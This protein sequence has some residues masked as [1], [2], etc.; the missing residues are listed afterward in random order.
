MKRFLH[1]LL[2]TCLMISLT[3]CTV[4]KAQSSQGTPGATSAQAT[5]ASQMPD[6]SRI[7]DATQASDSASG[8]QAVPAS[9]SD[10]IELT[11]EMY[12]TYI[13]EIYTNFDDY[14][15]RTIKLQGMFASEYYEPNQ[16]TYDYVYRVGPG[17]CGNDG[18]MCGF[19]F[20]WNG[21]MPEENDWIEVIGTLDKYDLEGQTYLT[22]KAQSVTE[23]SDRGAENVYR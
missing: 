3:G 1:F 17:C 6:A 5:D 15:G 9:N 19:E 20:S 21:E 13:N 14:I 22:L 2:A 10:V 4:E 18:S 8:A 16:T 7:P 11:E 23:M 12:V